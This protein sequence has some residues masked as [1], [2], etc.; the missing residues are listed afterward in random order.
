MRKILIIDD[1]PNICLVTKTVLEDI[2]GW[3]PLVAFSG[4][5]GLAIAQ[6]EQPNA[7][8]L[9]VEMPGMNGLM[10][11]E[12]LRANSETQLIP[13]ILF[14]G[15]VISAQRVAQLPIVGIIFKPFDAHELIKQTRLLLNWHE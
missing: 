12:Q 13:V 7:I 3:E 10:V 6:R 8:L 15:E 14:T 4:E 9:D 1:N 2:A 11:L 5:E